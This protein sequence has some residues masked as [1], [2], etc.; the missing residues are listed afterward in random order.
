MVRDEVLFL[1]C[2]IDHYSRF[3][4]REHLFIIVDGSDSLLPEDLDGCQVI[5]MPKGKPG[6]GWDRRRWQFLS[7]FAGALT[8]RFDVVIGGDVDELIVLDPDV[9]DDPIEF[10]VNR[11]D[12]PVISPFALEIIHRV[13]QEQPLSGDAPI[14]A[15]RKYVSPN[16]FYCKPCILRKAVTWSL[17]Q[18]YSDHP[19]LNLSEE[20]YLFHLRYVDH[21]ILMDRQKQ[22]NAQVTDE[23]NQFVSGTA[24]VGW[25]DSTEEKSAQLDAFAQCDVKEDKSFSFKWH[26]QKMKNRW[27]FET[28][29]GV[30][31][32]GRFNDTILYKVPD[33]FSGAF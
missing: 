32:H 7:Q 20:L 9:G 25:S 24:G 31:R 30:W 11:T 27:Q 19:D 4:P 29:R 2:W 23:N 8:H 28:K 14:M 1:K 15:Q 26:R 6:R 13:D 33:R 17:G 22:R 3:V 5:T 10:I 21:D 12:A 18:H 16:S